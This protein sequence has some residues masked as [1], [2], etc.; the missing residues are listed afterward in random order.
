LAK[1][2]GATQKLARESLLEWGSCEWHHTGKYAQRTNYFDVEE[3]IG[4]YC[5]DVEE[6]VIERRSSTTSETK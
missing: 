2:I 4:L 6:E 3:I 1:R 5:F